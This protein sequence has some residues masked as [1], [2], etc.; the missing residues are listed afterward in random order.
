MAFRNLDR[1]LLASACSIALVSPAWAQATAAADD[2]DTREIVVTA[3]NRTE[4]V[5][6][7]PIA[8]NVI[9]GRCNG[10]SMR[11]KDCRRES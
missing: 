9:S 6:D 3:Q 4:N 10:V 8:I 1:M 11:P 2:T 7:V 5:Q